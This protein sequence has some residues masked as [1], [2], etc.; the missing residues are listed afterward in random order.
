MIA[1]V[2]FLLAAALGK[3]L[4]SL[5]NLAIYVPSAYNKLTIV[6]SENL[7]KSAGCLFGGI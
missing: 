1:L 6:R 5:K 4:R 7:K 2:F 3:L